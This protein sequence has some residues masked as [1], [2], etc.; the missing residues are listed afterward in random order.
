MGRKP[1]PDDQKKKR[2]VL[3]LTAEDE[4]IIKKFLAAAELVVT[5]PVTEHQIEVAKELAPKARELIAAGCGKNP[6]KCQCAKCKKYRST[7][8]R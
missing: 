7:L 3:Y 4:A 6:L 2:V 1:L 8:Y 5:L